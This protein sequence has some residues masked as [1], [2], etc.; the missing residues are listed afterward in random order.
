MVSARLHARS[1]DWHRDR[2]SACR[3]GNAGSAQNGL[4]SAGDRGFLKPPPKAQAPII[5]Q[6]T[7]TAEIVR[8]LESGPSGVSNTRKGPPKGQAATQLKLSGKSTGGEALRAR[9]HAS[10]GNMSSSVSSTF[11]VCAMRHVPLLPEAS[12]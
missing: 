10:S 9:G 5:V 3:G 7:R 2:K 11:I 1:G 12:E 4:F 8:R 6:A